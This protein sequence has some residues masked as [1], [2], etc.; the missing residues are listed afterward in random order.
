MAKD[1]ADRERACFAAPSSTSWVI[2]LPCLI[3]IAVGQE[4]TTPPGYPAITLHSASSLVLIDVMARNTKNG[5][6]DKTL[7]R[8]DFLVSDNGR[9]VSI[10]RPASAWS[11]LRRAA[12]QRI[13]YRRKGGQQE[14]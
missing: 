6:P 9:P 8:D 10:A 4:T 3:A 13:R 12:G 11:V 2:L 14:G 5:L 1:S 7:K